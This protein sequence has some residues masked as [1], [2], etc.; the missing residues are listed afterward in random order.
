M[1]KYDVKYQWKE[2]KF[3]QRMHLDT[4]SSLNRKIRNQIS[5]LKQIAEQTMNIQTRYLE[6][7]KQWHTG[8]REVDLCEKKIICL[9]YASENTID[10]LN[11]IEEKGDY[12]EGFIFHELI[13]DMLFYA[14]DQLYD[15][16]IK[17]YKKKGIFLT[18]QFFPGENGISL[19]LQQSLLYRMK[20]ESKLPVEIN[21]HYMLIPEKAMLYVVGADEKNLEITWK[22]TCKM[23]DREHCYFRQ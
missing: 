19:D 10:I 8:I 16:L 22:H 17:Q 4:E 20:K 18:R 13:N 6:E 3:F 15:F 9:V 12:L 2:E 7:D 23:C 14:A 5:N 1:K 21:S 11:E